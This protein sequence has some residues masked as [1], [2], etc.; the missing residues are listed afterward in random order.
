MN[1]YFLKSITFLWCVDLFF[2]VAFLTC[3]DGRHSSLTYKAII[4]CQEPLLRHFCLTGKQTLQAPVQYS[5]S[6]TEWAL[7]NQDLS[8]SPRNEPC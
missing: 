1:G 6:L 8:L 4:P 3:L 2:I 7:P 5:L